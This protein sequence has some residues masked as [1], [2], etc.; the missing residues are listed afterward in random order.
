[1][2]KVGARSVQ[3]L[4]SL[5]WV[6]EDNA[7]YFNAKMNNNATAYLLVNDVSIVLNECNR[8]IYIEGYFSKINFAE[9]NC[10]FLIAKVGS[11]ILLVIDFQQ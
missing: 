10:R 2:F 9:K 8:A 3:S 4:G 1:M 7:L 11:F 6:S 5:Y